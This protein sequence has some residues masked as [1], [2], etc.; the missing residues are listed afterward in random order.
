MALMTNDETVVT[1]GRT[2]EFEQRVLVLAPVGRDGP[3]TV[4]ALQERNIPAG[5]CANVPILCKEIEA[6]AAAVILTTESLD[7]DGMGLLCSGL[8]HQ[9]PWSDLPII[10]MASSSG[11]REEEAVD[12]P[13]RNVTVLERP[14]RLHFLIS[15]VQSALRARRRQYEVRDLLRQ[16]EKAREEAEHQHARIEQL[17]DRLR[18]AMRETHHRVK[19]NLQIIAAMI[20]MQ[21]LEG[22]ATVPTEELRRL[23]AHVRTLAVVHDMLTQQAKD[24]G[25][26]QYVSAKAVLNS[27]MPLIVQTAGGRQIDFKIEDAWLSARQSASLAIVVNE[28]VS[29]ALKHGKG[30]VDVKLV[31]SDDRICLVVL[32]DGPGFPQDFDPVKASNTGLELIEHLSAWDL[33]GHVCFNNRPGGGAAVT[34][35]FPLVTSEEPHPDEG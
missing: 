4:Q 11:N 1:D 24:D 25:Q 14:I 7:N 29:N 10:L 15:T 2:K 18:Q 30:R 22:K 21:L 34:V 17:N 8:E 16:A 12:L 33:R 6:G 5:L 28:L 31:V 35:E 13:L 26:A 9:P 32:D 3:L 23:S 19:N 20:D 27:L